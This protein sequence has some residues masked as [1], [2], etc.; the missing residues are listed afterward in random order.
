MIE[1]VRHW[2]FGRWILASETLFMARGYAVPWLVA[3]FLGTTSTGIFV[4]YLTIVALANPLLHGIS[5]VLAPD[6]ARAH[7]E[8]G[9]GE[10]R[11]LV[12]KATLALGAATLLFGIGLGIFGESLIG[13]VYGEEFLGYPLCV[14]ILAAGFIVEAVGMPAYDGLWA[15]ERSNAC[16]V[17]CLGGLT[18]TILVTV[19]LTP[20][21][22][23][24]GAAS[25]ISTGRLTATV[26]QCFAFRRCL[27]EGQLE[28][29]TK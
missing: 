4:A 16:F 22:G 5:N 18:A 24:A 28:G 17:A 3:A 13:L 12:I 29:A 2:R 25:G 8:E 21:W 23:L 27:R 20:L 10:V 6:L 7:A 11:R 1:A 14:V 26:I 19:L 9:I 15:V